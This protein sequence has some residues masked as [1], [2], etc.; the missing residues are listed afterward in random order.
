MCAHL[1][2]YFMFSR[3]LNAKCSHTFHFFHIYVVCETGRRTF[4]FKL[5]LS[6]SLATMLSSSNLKISNNW[7]RSFSRRIQKRSEF[8][9]RFHIIKWKWV[10]TVRV[11]YWLLLLNAYT[12]FSTYLHTYCFSFL[13]LRMSCSWTAIT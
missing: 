5:S 8:K 11:W 1:W 3:L 9:N 13:M 6:I 2:Q 4:F 10:H 12:T 7:M